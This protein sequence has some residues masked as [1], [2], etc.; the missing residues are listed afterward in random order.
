MKAGGRLEAWLV[1]A[2]RWLLYHLTD[3]G[4]RVV[5][6]ESMRRTQEDADLLAEVRRATDEVRRD[7]MGADDFA[8]RIT[9]MVTGQDEAR[10]QRDRHRVARL[11]VAG[12]RGRDA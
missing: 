12:F 5:S 3:D 6:Y 2:A 4:W 11:L 1:G 7:R 9:S 8:G 10:Q